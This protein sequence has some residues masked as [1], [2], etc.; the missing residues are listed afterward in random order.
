MFLETHSPLQE[1]IRFSYREKE[2]TVVE[3]LLKEISFTGEQGR[4]IQARAHELVMRM[5]TDKE[6]GDVTDAFMQKFPLSNPEGVLLMCLA[7][8]LLRIPDKSTAKALLEDKLLQADFRKHLGQSS[9]TLVNLSTRG[10]TMARDLLKGGSGEGGIIDRLKTALAQTSEPLIRQSALQAMQM[11]ANKF[12]MGKTIQEALKKAKTDRK[13]GYTHSYDMLG[14]AAFTAE[15]AKRYFQA[16]AAAIEALGE[17]NP[18]LPES[19]KGTISI[20]LSALHPR[21]AYAQKERVMTELYASLLALCTK[22]KE[23]DVGL[24]IDAEEAERLELSLALLEKLAYDQALAGWDGLGLAV[25]AYQKRAVAI[26][27]FLADLA[28]QTKRRFN[29]RLVKGAYWDSEIKRTQEAGLKDYPVFTRKASTDLS[30]LVCA[31]YML[32]HRDVFY[33]QFATHNAQTLSAIMEMSGE[34]RDFEFQKL[35]GMGNDLYAHITGDQKE[36]VL[37]RI[38]APIGQYKDLLPYLVRRLLENGANSSFV[39]HIYDEETPL[40]NIIENPLEKVKRTMPA[41]HP[42]I[43]LPRDLYPAVRLNSLG[44]DLTDE[45]ETNPILKAIN[46]GKSWLAKPLIGG[47]SKSGRPLKCYNPAD[48]R[49]EI[50]EVVEATNEHAAE[51][52]ALAEKASRTWILSAAE[53]RAKALEKMADLLE[54]DRYELMALAVKEGGKSVPDAVAEIREAVDFCRYYANRGREDFGKGIS[55]PGPTGEKNELRLLGRGI[56]V[57]IS[58][59]NF[60]LAIFTGQIAAALM[61]GNCVIAKPARQTPLIAHK[62][63]QLFHEAGIPGNVLHFL[64]G[65]G[66]RIAARLIED[67]RTAGVCFTGS[68]ETAWH[69]NRTLAAREDIIVPFIAETGGQNV[70][71][72]DSSSLPEQVVNDV[73]TSAFQSAGQR[74]SALRV[75]MLQE[76]IAEH[77]IEMLRGAMAELVVGDPKELS[78]DVGPVIDPGA[79]ETLEEHINQMKKKARLIYQCTLD[80]ARTEHGNFVPPTAFE[81]DSLHLLKKEVFGPILHIVR[82]RAEALDR[83]IEEIN[84]LR[85]GLTFGLH[86]RIDRKV[87]S[88][89]KKIRAGNIYVNR[90][91]IGAVV[92]VQPFGGMGLSGTGPKAGGPFYLHRFATEQTVTI[93]TTA[94][95]GNTTLMNLD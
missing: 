53:D 24:T 79:Q 26:L 91:M 89:P 84:S 28:K 46:K 16:Y 58:P 3:N 13:K 8:A 49:N 40:E 2:E 87:E 74:C 41:H 62:A 19:Q 78:T 36:G 72:V 10:L 39:N 66:S 51:A 60:P 29:I 5:R 15:D 45:T 59:W 17:E 70:M 21:Y 85:Y 95:G 48:R 90:N 12:V 30:Y 23:F 44:S 56:F 18:M 82:Y 50:G 93:N 76:E 43:P 80:K 75:L 86:T 6:K 63:I 38:Y 37:C 32:H 27:A 31:Q 94:Q 52:L 11:L 9:S 67:K 25:Q 92:G 54:R 57:C 68:T 35:Y 77:V 20:K 88:V 42:K 22:A 14:E 47:L 71:L 73:L 1:A 55:L 7:E 33:C 81:I 64:P 69:I 83:V 65:P 34:S 61:A 4:R